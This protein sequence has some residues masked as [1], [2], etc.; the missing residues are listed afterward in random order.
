MSRY[1]VSGS[2][3]GPVLE[4]LLGITDVESLNT[5]EFIGFAWAANKA[6]ED[7]TEETVFDVVYLKTLHSSAL[8]H[9]YGFA[10]RLRDVNMSKDGFMFAPAGFLESSLKTCEADFLDKI[11][12]NSSD[13][14]EKLLEQLAD[15]HA[16]L[17]FIHPFREGNGRTI[18]LFTRLVYLAKTGKEIDFEEKITSSAA[19]RRRYI[20]GVQQAAKGEYSP[21]RALFRELKA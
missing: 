20:E 10:G 7:L 4:N 18:R 8:G 3:D 21:M 11:N 17:L 12:A 13:S 15:M 9:I 2:T 19:V 1:Y 16:E 14:E 5:E 6:I